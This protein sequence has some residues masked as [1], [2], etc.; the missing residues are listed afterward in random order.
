MYSQ[1]ITLLLIC[2]CQDIT[3]LLHL[4]CQVITLRYEQ[5]KATNRTIGEQIERI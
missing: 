5:E 1:A 3:L 2:L 4:L